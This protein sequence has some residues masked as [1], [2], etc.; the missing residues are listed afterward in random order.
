MTFPG[1][2]AGASIRSTPTVKSRWQRR[3]WNG[4]GAFLA[5]STGERGHYEIAAG[6]DPLPFIQS[7]ERFAGDTGLLAQQLWDSDDILEKT[8]FYGKPSGSAMPLCWSHENISRLSVP[9]AMAKSSIA[10]SQ[11]FSAMRWEVSAIAPTRCGISGTEP[12]TFRWAGL[13]A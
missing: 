11:P 10:S 12:G 2:R 3:R 8:M 13:C 5:N 6:R 9:A 7:M 1:A 4:R